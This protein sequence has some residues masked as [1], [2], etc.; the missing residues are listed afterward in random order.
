M[1][2]Q[3]D[4]GFYSYEQSAQMYG[5][6]EEI[7]YQDAE[8]AMEDNGLHMTAFG[9][10]ANPKPQ[11][12]YTITRG[13]EK[14]AF[15]KAVRLLRDGDL[16]IQ[17]KALLTV[18]EL[19]RTGEACVQL[20]HA[21]VVAALTECLGAPDPTVRQRAAAD[22][23][24]LVG[25]AGTRGCTQMLT[26]GAVETLLSLLDDVST[27]VRHAVYNALVEACARSPAIQA[28]L[29]SIDGTLAGLLARAGD[30]TGEEDLER[31]ACA[32]ELIRV[33]LAGRNPGAAE[34]LLDAGGLAALV[35]IMSK[36]DIA[37]V[38][39]ATTVLGLLCAEWKAKEEAVKVGAVAALTNLMGA[40]A[41]LS[42]KIVAVHALMHICVD[43][44]GKAAA[45]K[46]GAVPLISQALEVDDEKL[47][48][49]SLQCVASI[50]ENK[51]G[52]A[53]LQPV[54]PRLAQLMYHHITVIQRH[55]MLAK[56]AVE[57]KELGK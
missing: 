35:Q 15:P 1:Q 45:V 56:R 50:A 31:M 51:A 8:Y 55:A 40:H 6:A 29:C 18:S 43:I 10:Q 54:A 16:E 26:D 5:G 38:E 44:V 28:R 34:Q 2:G 12:K 17:Q 36:Q 42:T 21:G 25:V 49:N 22:F 7:A 3:E 4:V 33:C 32:L 57:F 41:L 20:V 53:A 19:L 9:A 24:I 39:G 48:L 30:H 13:W 46:A 27:P 11:G 14:F 37:V 47:I 23:E 52:R